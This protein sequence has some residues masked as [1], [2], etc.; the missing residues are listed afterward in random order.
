MAF[1]PNR[2]HRTRNI[3][4]VA[5]L[6]LSL[7]GC[8][9]IR[10]WDPFGKKQ[11]PL[12]GER[13]AVLA[14]ERSLQADI[15][16][17]QADI[18]LPAPTPNPDW[19]QAG[20][21]ADHAMHHIAVRDT[22][23]EAWARDIGA[24]A[25]DDVRFI[26]SPIIA[27]K[28]V[29]AI[30]TDS[31]VTA[32]DIAS[33]DTKWS[34]QLESETDDELQIGG[35]LAYERGQVFATTGFGVVFAMDAATGEIKWSRSLGLPLRT[36]PTVRG[37]R[38]F[39]VSVDNILNALDARD[40]S[41]LWT[42]QGGQEIAALLGGASPAVSSGTVVVPYSTGEAFALRVDDGKVLWQDN[43]VSIQR[44][45]A[46]A[47]LTQIRGRPIIDRGLVIAISHAGVLA[48]IDLRTGRR[49][50]AR[51]IGGAE[52][53]WIAGDYL[54]LI[55]NDK[56]LVCVSRDDGKVL[57]VRG[58]ARFEDEKD[59][60]DPIIWTGPILVSDRLIVAGS[61]GQALAVSPYDGHILGFQEMPDSV[62]VAPVVADGYIFFLADDAELVA[63][64]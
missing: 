32:Y 49:K 59:Q 22:L 63:Y 35:G 46:I 51:D 3:V 28:T 48:A 31:E 17:G 58:L 12:P 60:E 6:L 21:Y 7:G 24:G 53:P 15:A 38:V 39:V 52:S 40:G 9:A 37:G 29:F 26:G 64:Q 41:V 50:W 13:I 43:L 8:D 23:T 34:R 55:T 19:P 30:D 57:W 5:M 2:F 45:D 61:N 20:G 16:P 47:A 36:P 27:D 25:D 1:F 42:H 33:G 44:T 11:V 18:L 54:Y 56:E 10:D 4:V 14:N 62:S